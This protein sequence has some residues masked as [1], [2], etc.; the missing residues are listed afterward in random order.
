[1]VSPIFINP[2][3]N[4]F[5]EGTPFQKFFKLL[6]PLIALYLGVLALVYALLLFIGL[7]ALA[8]IYCVELYPRIPQAFGGARPYYA[9]L[10]VVKAQMSPET[11]EG[12]LP[13]DANKSHESVVRSSRLEVLFSGSDVMLVRSRGK[14]YKITKSTIQTIAMCD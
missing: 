7:A 2:L 9:C 10:D 6:H 11:I 4:A 14:V 1:M 12:L 3:E 13:P 8:F 5:A